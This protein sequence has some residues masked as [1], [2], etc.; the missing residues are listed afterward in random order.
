MARSEYEKKQAILDY[1]TVKAP[2]SGTV[3]ER[4]V[5][6]GSFVQNASTGHPTPVLTLER[7]GHVTVVMRVPDN[8]ASFITAGTEAAIEWAVALPG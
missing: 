2:F 7:D 6:P 1:A 8:A 5:D 3:I 4:K